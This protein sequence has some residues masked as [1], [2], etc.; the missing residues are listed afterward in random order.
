M[1][2]M[3]D[4]LFHGRRS[5]GWLWALLWVSAT[6]VG[7]GSEN[8][9]EVGPSGAIC[10]TDS[11]LSY[12]SF[13]RDFMQR[14]CTRCHGSNLAGSAR[15]GAPSGHDFDTLESI[16]RTPIEHID[17]QAAAGIFQ[18]NTAMPPDAPRPTEPE[19]RELGEWLACGL[20]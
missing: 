17:E 16:Q 3:S 15:H 2:G 8:E 6:A 9:Q 5:I 4:A 12:Q 1:K 20:P 7:C 14:Y 18:I 10:S 13:G 11:S 19:R